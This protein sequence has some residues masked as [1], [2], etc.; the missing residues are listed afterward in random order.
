MAQKRKIAENRRFEGENQQQVWVRGLGGSSSSW[1]RLPRLPALTGSWAAPA[2]GGDLVLPAATLTCS[3]S[4]PLQ[5]C[6][7]WGG[8]RR[9][10]GTRRAGTQKVPWERL[11]ASRCF[12]GGVMP[13]GL[14]QGRA[15]LHR[16]GSPA[17]SPKMP[18]GTEKAP[19]AI[20]CAPQTPREP[21]VPPGAGAPVPAQQVGRD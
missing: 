6:W 18:S 5:L 19:S 21:A 4:L 1:D 20:P 3:G 14:Q 13:E 11:G 16:P 7:W 2:R 12:F 10:G 17:P 8:R 15:H 9:A